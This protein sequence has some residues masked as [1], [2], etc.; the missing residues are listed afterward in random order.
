MAFVVIQH[1]SPKFKSMMDT[2]LRRC[3][4]IPI[5]VVENGVEVLPNHVYLI[6][7]AK[8]MIY[9][10]GRLV[11]SDH[12][13]DEA[14]HLPIDR[15][16][17]SLGRAGLEQAAA[18]ILSGTGSDGAR[19]LRAVNSA[20]GIVL[21]ESR[22]T[23]AFGGMPRSA[24]ET[25]VVDAILAPE[26]M[27][28]ALERA[29]RA[30]G[31]TASPV[32]SDSAMDELLKALRTSFDIDFSLYKRT[33]LERRLERRAEMARHTDVDS[34]LREAA[35]DPTELK[36]IFEDVLIG[37]T[38]FFRD[39]EF[40]DS[41]SKLMEERMRDRREDEQFRIWSAGCA[42]GQEPYSLA[43]LATEAAE[44]AG[45]DIE[46]QV[47][48]SDIH[49]GSLE[50]AMSGIYSVD[51]LEAVSEERLERFFERVDDHRFRINSVL[52]KRV[53]FAQHDLLHDAPFTKVDVVSCRN[54][55]IYLRAE[56]Q[57]RALAYI[58]FALAPRGILALGPSEA[59]GI[60]RD[61]FEALDEHNRIYKARHQTTHTLLPAPFRTPARPRPVERGH[62]NTMMATYDALCDRF[63][64]PGFLLDEQR[65][66]LDSFAGAERYLAVGGRRMSTDFLTLFTTADKGAVVSGLRTA[67]RSSEPVR[68]P[69]VVV[70]GPNGE[71][72]IDLVIERLPI[73]NDG[74]N[75][76]ITLGEPKPRET[77]VSM[78]EPR[79]PAGGQ[80]LVGQLEHELQDTR[81]QLQQAIEELES[82][83][84]ELQ[85]TNEELIASNEELQATNE[86]LSSVNEELYTVNTEYQSTI[87][88]LHDANAAMEQL[89][90]ATEVATIFVDESITIQRLTPSATNI[91][92]ATDRD[93]GRSLASFRHKLAW[94]GL[95]DA[96]RKLL[97]TGEAFSQESVSD[98][99]ERSW[100][101]RAHAYE[102]YDGTNGAVVT[103]TDVTEL[104]HARAEVRRSERRLTEATDAIPILLS[105][106]DRDERYVFVNGTYEKVW[107]KP[108]SEIVGSSVRDLLGDAAYEE[109]KKSFTKAL[110]GEPA[111]AE[112][113]IEFADGRNQ[114]FTVSYTPAVDEND[115]VTGVYTTA[116]DITHRRKME[117]E[118]EEAR[119]AASNAAS[120]KSEFL[121]NMSHEIRSPMTAILGY[122]DLI[123]SEA[124]DEKVAEHVATI[125]RNGRHLIGVIDD[126]LDLSR[127]EYGAE[128]EAAVHVSPA[129]SV[130]EVFELFRLRAEEKGLRL[131]L[132]LA[133]LL[134]REIKTQPQRIRQILINL[135]SN[136]IKFTHEGSVHM[137][138]D[139]DRHRDGSM[140]LRF[141]VSDTGVGFPSERAGDLFEPFRQLDGSHT[142]AYEGAG[143]GL[144]ISQRL[145]H[146]LGGTLTASSA[147]SA[148]SKFVFRL[149]VSEEAAQDL[150][151][152][153]VREV[154]HDPGRSQIVDIQG[155][156][157]VVDDSPDIRMLL[158]DILEAAGA[159]V[160]TASSGREALDRVA[161]DERYD[162]ILLDIQMP[163]MDG[164]ECARHLRANGY[165]D[166]II[167]VTARALRTDREQC[168]DAGC[169]DYL[170]KPVDTGKLTQRIADL[171]GIAKASS[172]AE[173]EAPEQDSNGAS[174][175]TKDSTNGTRRILVVEDDEDTAE[176]L[177]MVLEK[178]GFDASRVGTVAAAVDAWQERQPHIIFC[179]LGLA[180][181]DGRTLA[182]TIR[183]DGDK[184]TRL[185]AVTGRHNAQAQV[186][187]A[188]FD[189]CLMKPVSID[190]LIAA[191]ETSDVS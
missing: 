176:L 59:T 10:D 106:F 53:V 177:V 69:R 178:R 26:E 188:G 151:P 144:A 71:E 82:A 109:A 40:F 17:D 183:A 80:H 85:A 49:A 160:A 184:T 166:A 91:L 95:V 127:I 47:F 97:A 76:L 23:A 125:R 165:Q 55:M 96:I 58:R 99:G 34:Y 150:T 98:D 21:V 57:K 186:K 2:L 15:F 50:R 152:P 187:D 169:N 41:L 142:R 146:K 88:K 180:D 75:L 185:I 114:F 101:I 3:T 174:K 63:M 33:T 43:M 172:K 32:E 36:L 89:F 72:R 92:D 61:D 79:S 24:I 118:L 51:D 83:N 149:P 66:V 148:G 4:D 94:N 60:L 137:A 112:M 155:S 84:E 81:L 108:R 124:K 44:R 25:G 133:P 154:L 9:A 191:V 20:G 13:P 11:L 5:D 119:L 182:E 90:E 179:D 138:L 74:S 42:T 7:P 16:L 105:H 1:L 167:A 28:A 67:E 117:L 39:R 140:E 111:H 121:A 175:P 162:V 128:L 31:E 168:L 103:F 141:S 159:K 30:D 164:L 52:R 38:Q 107:G 143:L 12:D 93:I 6:P 87:A 120:A 65:N 135:V 62:R 181:G 163:G 122:A 46:I 113:E 158:A 8:R 123:A 130:V 129:Q 14:V 27:P 116:T 54:M 70:D 18:V 48:G 145:A 100:Y 170:T 86:E 139:L 68:I 153:N 190:A 29:F 64:P 173:S 22:A 157:L 126:V 189:G 132:A 19:G 73:G 78:P 45:K 156:L 147:P 110:A 35:A 104:A 102:S 171:I 115:H 131:D 134:P 161:R 77:S 56:G 136:A 37:V